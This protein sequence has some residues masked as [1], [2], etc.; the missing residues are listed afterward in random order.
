MST[1]PSSWAIYR[2]LLGRARRYWPYLAAAGVGMLFE[3][4]AAGAFT[5]MMEPMVNGTFVD[6]NPEVRWTLPLAIVGLFLVRGIATFCTD[7][8]MSRAGRGVVRDLREDV[9]AKYLR[10]PSSR[11]DTEPVPSMVS[12]LNYD[13]EQV[14]QASS[15]AIK[16]ILTDSLTIVVLLGVMFYWS[17]K[18]T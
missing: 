3:A 17:P 10:L 18:V 7:Y 14:T 16:V 9:L 2:R 11:F 1:E 15:D 6:K 5:W 4:G 8:G 13:T 12:R